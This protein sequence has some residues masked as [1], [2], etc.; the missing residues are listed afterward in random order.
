MLANEQ[1]INDLLKAVSKLNAPPSFRKILSCVHCR[2]YTEEPLYF[3]IKSD[4]CSKHDYTFRM[5]EH[6]DHTCDDFKSKY[7]VGEAE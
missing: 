1:P 4:V 7:E 5:F 2:F 6:R 3:H